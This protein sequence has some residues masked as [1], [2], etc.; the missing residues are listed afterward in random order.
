MPKS[1]YGE[2]RVQT[3]AITTMPIAEKINMVNQRFA[4]IM[5]QITSE[6]AIENKPGLM[7]R[8]VL[9]NKL[10]QTLSRP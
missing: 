2:K 4:S 3:K 9:F 8:I 7:E 10:V 6:G 1:I 5:Q